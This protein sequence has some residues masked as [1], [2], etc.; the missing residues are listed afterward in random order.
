MS[1]PID[2]CQFVHELLTEEK[3]SMD[4]AFSI[5]ASEFK[6]RRITF[7][8][9]AL[10]QKYYRWKTQNGIESINNNRALSNHE[11]QHLVEV[12][13]SLAALK[14]P[15][16]RNAIHEVVHNVFGVK[17]S[18][19]F[20]NRFL[21]RHAEKL[22]LVRHSVVPKAYTNTE[23]KSH[24]ESWIAAYYDI[25]SEFNYNASEIIAFDESSLTLDNSAKLVVVGKEQD[26]NMIGKK[27][28]AVG[29]V[30]PFVSADGKCVAVFFLLKNRKEGN[31]EFNV[32]LPITDKA[33][34]F[35]SFWCWNKNGYLDEVTMLLMLQKIGTIMGEKRALFL[36]D[37]FEAHHTTKVRSFYDGVKY[38]LCLFVANLSYKHNPLDNAMNATLKKTFRAT[39]SRNQWLAALT[40]APILYMFFESMYEAVFKAYSPDIVI[41]S[42]ANTG[43]WP[44][45]KYTLRKS[46]QE[47]TGSTTQTPESKLANSVVKI[48]R[49]AEKEVAD[50]V[51]RVKKVRTNIDGEVI[52]TSIQIRDD[53]EQRRKIKDA[54]DEE[55]RKEEESR[56]C[57]FPGCS[58][59]QRKNV[60]V[61]VCPN[62]SQAIC[63]K[64]RAPF[65]CCSLDNELDTNMSEG[66]KMDEGEVNESR[67]TLLV[68]SPILFNEVN[69]DPFQSPSVF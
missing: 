3:H 13:Y 29:T 10:R 44:I 37:Q 26:H 55:K 14:A 25:V 50:V 52:Y 42:F 9:K 12:I 36:C 32:F 67:N 54:A 39:F 66:Q 19:C 4:E 48:I 43:V 49:S 23:L 68:H 21:D 30:V 57:S 40:G 24:M 46:A 8:T 53:E 38:V 20:A 15:I 62:C 41:R 35:P 56:K 61:R 47:A 65:L 27:T 59:I 6:R 5:T 11:E 17:V 2:A 45:S 51:K 64:H 22:K 34:T 33:L 7:T 63:K 1:V 31:R 18:S 16:Q 28:P 58:G 69:N 60:V